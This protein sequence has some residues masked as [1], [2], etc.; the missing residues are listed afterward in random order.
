MKWYQ[1]LYFHYTHRQNQKQYGQT[2][3]SKFQHNRQRNTL[4][5][6]SIAVELLRVSSS[7][8]ISA[9]NE[10]AAG[11]KLMIKAGLHIDF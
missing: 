4:L 1:S 10:A 2:L 8:F 5:F 7:P 9:V 6:V 3:L 11:K